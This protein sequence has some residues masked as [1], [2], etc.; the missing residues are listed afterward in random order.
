[1]CG[2]FSLT[3]EEQR[4]ND[5]FRLA[6]GSE[7]YVPRYNGAPTQSLAVITASEP[8]RLQYF[9]WGLVLNWSKEVSRSTPVI[10]ARAESLDEKP[11]FRQAFKKRR[12][13]VPADG[14]YEWVH[15]GKKQP[16]RFQMKDDSPFAMAGIWEQWSQKPGETLFSFAIVTTSP[17][18]LMEPIHNRMPV[19]L[20][21][22]SYDAWLNSSDE[23]ELHEMLK[24]YPDS[25]MKTYKISDKVNSV[26]SEGPELFKPMEE[27][28]L[29]SFS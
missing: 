19:I 22:D 29:F 9:R 23:N 16:F 10:N 26:K 11:M 3:T 6:G 25:R 5:F 15:T 20:P 17:N 7:P 2:R 28:D 12:C 21:T 8:H 4:L 1:M 27:A 18:T 24:P 14:F 13:L